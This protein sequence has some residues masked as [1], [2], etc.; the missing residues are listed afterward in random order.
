MDAKT[1][2][3]RK[4]ISIQLT[5]CI[6]IPRGFCLPISE[7]MRQAKDRDQIVLNKSNDQKEGPSYNI[8]IISHSQQTMEVRT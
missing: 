8:R 6:D 5:H 1:R 2:S 7:S 3:H 4:A